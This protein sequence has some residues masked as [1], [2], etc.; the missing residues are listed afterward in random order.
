MA[1]DIK[2]YI[3]KDVILDVYFDDP[4]GSTRPS[5]GDYIPVGAL[6]TKD[7][8][9]EYDTVDATA[10][11]TVGG[12]RENLTTFKSFSVTGDGT[13]KKADDSLSNQTALFKYTVN[14]TSGTPCAWVRLT[15][16]DVTIEVFCLLTNASR[17]G[18]YDDVVTFNFEASST[19]SDFGIIVED[20]PTP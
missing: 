11:D 19:V 17:S 20:T 12:I 1:L 9:I 2:K 18:T 10:D 8:T 3:G 7:M 5:S 6:R 15:Y 16:P 4:S 14:P 13:A